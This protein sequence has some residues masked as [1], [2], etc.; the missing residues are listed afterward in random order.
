MTTLAVID[1]I[2]EEVSALLNRISELHANDPSTE[3]IIVNL[4]DHTLDF[5]QWRAQAN[6]TL[7]DGFDI[8]AEIELDFAHLLEE[9]LSEL[10]LTKENSLAAAI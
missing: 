4:T 8:Y 1:Q 9:W 6:I 7:F 5:Q 3:L 10:H 2:D